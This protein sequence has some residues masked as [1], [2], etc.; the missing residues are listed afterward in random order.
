MD[1]HLIWD[2]VT[3]PES[4]SRKEREAREKL[5][6]SA[7]HSD[8]NSV[9][10][11]LRQNSEWVNFTKVGGVSRYTPLH[12]AAYNGAPIEVVEVLLYMGAWRAIRNQHGKRPIDIAQDQ[13]HQHL[14][15]ILEPVYHQKIPTDI[16]QDLQ[17]N[18]HDV[19]IGR[20]KEQVEE[21]QL[22][23][24]ELEPMLE[25]DSACPFWFGIPGMFGGFKYWLENRWDSTLLISESWSY[26][27]KGSGE[28]HIVTPFGCTLVA[29]GFV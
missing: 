23:L 7:Y 22:N 29:K 3:Q 24:P 12:Q 26:V 16:L 9:F 8:W 11:I 20:A 10:Q 5:A 4:L 19:I 6:S 28:R 25:Y 15:E 21:N 27:V 13:N 2:G 17:N 14:F 18:F 1:A